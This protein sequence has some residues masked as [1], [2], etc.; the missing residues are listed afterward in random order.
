MDWVGVARLA[1][2]RQ[3]R[4]GDEGREEANPNQGTPDIFRLCMGPKVVGR[5]PV[6]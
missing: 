4:R 2:A 5:D 1:L 3:E 6:H